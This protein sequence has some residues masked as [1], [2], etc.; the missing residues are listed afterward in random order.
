[1]KKEDQ[2]ERYTILIIDDE[3]GPRESLRILFKNKYD[4]ITAENGFK[5]LEILKSQKVDIVILDLKMPQKNGIEVLSE[6]RQINKNVPVII[7]T[8]YGDMESAK[9]AMQ[10]DIVGFVSKPFEIIEIEELVENGIEKGKVKIKIGEIKEKILNLKEKIKEKEEEIKK[11]FETHKITEEN[12][13]EIKKSLEVVQNYA[14]SIFKEL[15]SETQQFSLKELLKT[16]EEIETCFSIIENIIELSIEKEFEEI[17]VNKLIENIVSLLKIFTEKQNI[18]FETLFSKQPLKIKGNFY[19]L[20]TSIISLLLEYIRE[21][22]NVKQVII[23]TSKTDD[24]AKIKF[25]LKTEEEEISEKNYFLEMM[26]E[27]VKRYHGKLEITTNIE[28]EIHISIIFPI[29]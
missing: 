25:K 2:K 1:M 24:S 15:S 27:V 19:Q 26:E 5:G 3:I 16:E 28:K 29:S 7:L 18:E 10:Y 6:I 13:K 8:G 4:V 21:L 9:K 22:K 23:E 11:L 17:D 20:N 14:E 12:L